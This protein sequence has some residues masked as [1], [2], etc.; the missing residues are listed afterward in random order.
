MSVIKLVTLKLTLEGKNFNLSGFV[1]IVMSTDTPGGEQ[2]GRSFWLRG[3]SLPR[4]AAI[5]LH[6]LKNT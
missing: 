1:D 4:Q 3:L 2:I 5:L 6:F